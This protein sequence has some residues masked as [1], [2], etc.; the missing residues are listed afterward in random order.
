V[1]QRSR[2]DQ[3]VRKSDPY[4]ASDLACPLCDSPIDRNLFEAA[5]QSASDGQLV[6]RTG[7]QLS[8]GHDRVR[9]FGLSAWE[10]RNTLEVV[11]EHIGVDN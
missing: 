1:H 2:C 4:V 6:L 9:Q 3:C 10:S 8:A 11:D 5:E 7:E